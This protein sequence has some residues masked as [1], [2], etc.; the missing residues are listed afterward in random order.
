MLCMRSDVGC[1][2]MCREGSTGNPPWSASESTAGNRYRGEGILPSQSNDRDVRCGAH[3][4]SSL[5][6]LPVNPRLLTS[7]CFKADGTASARPQRV[8]TLQKKP[9]ADTCIRRSAYEAFNN[10]DSLL[11][12]VYSMRHGPLHVKTSLCT[13][14]S[15]VSRHPVALFY[16]T[17]KS[18]DACNQA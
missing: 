1:R 14:I 4:V 12:N 2:A 8:V 11:Y 3:S 18:P 6:G 16:M 13:E 5:P 17:C 9:H 15:L 10:I 7:R